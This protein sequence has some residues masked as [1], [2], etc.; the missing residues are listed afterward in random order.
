MFFASTDEFDSQYKVCCQH[1][2]IQLS[3][4]NLIASTTKS[5]AST[6]ID[7]PASPS[8]NMMRQCGTESKT[9]S[10]EWTNVPLPPQLEAPR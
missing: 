8:L 5:P 6:Q 7:L 3:V 10:P 9:E 2:K 1:N 4:Q